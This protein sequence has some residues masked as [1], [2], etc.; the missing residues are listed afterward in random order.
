MIRYVV[1]RF[2]RINSDGTEALVPT[3]DIGTPYETRVEAELKLAQTNKAFEVFIR[4]D[5]F[6]FAVVS[7]I[8]S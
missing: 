6:S 8:A 4:T 7:Q 3:Q 2:E 1:S 5:R